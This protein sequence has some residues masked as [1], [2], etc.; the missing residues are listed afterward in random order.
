MSGPAVGNYKDTESQ[1]PDA[2]VGSATLLYKRKDSRL[3]VLNL[4]WYFGK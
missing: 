3:F 4:F 2:R 1:I